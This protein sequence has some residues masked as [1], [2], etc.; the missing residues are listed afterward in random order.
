MEINSDKDFQNIPIVIQ[1]ASALCSSKEGGFP[2]IVLTFP[3]YR[4]CKLPAKSKLWV[5]FQPEEG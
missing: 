1:L 2:P 3:E 5:K 4:V